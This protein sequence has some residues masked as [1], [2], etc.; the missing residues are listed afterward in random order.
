MRAEPNSDEIEAVYLSLPPE[1]LAAR[2]AD[3]YERARSSG[4]VREL[5]ALGR[6]LSGIDPRRKTEAPYLAR[7]LLARAIH[8]EPGNASAWFHYGRALRTNGTPDEMFAAWER[9]LSL[10]PDDALRVQIYTWIG[11]QR[12]VLSQP[13][14]A[15]AAFAAAHKINRQPVLRQPRWA[16]EYFGF[17]QRSIQ[18]GR[19]RGRCSR[20]F[21]GGAPASFPR[22]SSVHG[23]RWRAKTGRPRFETPNTCCATPPAMWNSSVERTPC[24]PGRTTC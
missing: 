3:R 6:A 7:G 16:W 1:I 15:G 9:A 8:L 14:P 4:D 5:I 17:L 18:A 21:C 19:R 10:Q 12:S 13:E 2:W 20:R 11:K 24:W 23:Y 22:C